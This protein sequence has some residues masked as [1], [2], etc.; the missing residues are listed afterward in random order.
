MANNPYIF[1]SSEG[2]LYG[3]GKYGGVNNEGYLYA[4]NTTTGE[5]SII[6]DLDYYGS[7][8]FTEAP[9]G[10]IYGTLQYTDGIDGAGSLFKITALDESFSTLLGFPVEIDDKFLV[11]PT[12]IKMSGDFLYLIIMDYTPPP[13]EGLIP[14][15][16]SFDLN[17]SVTSYFSNTQLSNGLYL[18]NDDSIFG[19]NL[20][21][22]S[23]LDKLYSVVSGDDGVT[24]LF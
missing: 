12:L 2:I 23:Y 7:A 8:Y 24:T 5:F 1:F 4:F 13:F 20:S 16:F 14:L 9:N 10:D 11:T 18:M 15:L 6:H 19:T 21:A 22:G 17:S 3:V